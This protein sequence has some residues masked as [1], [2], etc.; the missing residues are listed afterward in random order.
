L[1]SK[2]ADRHLR[3]ARFLYGRRRDALMKALRRV[4][5]DGAKAGTPRG[6]VNVW[7][8]LPP[9]WSSVDLFGYAAREGVLFLPGAAFFPTM[10][11]HNALRLS[12]GTLPEELAPEAMARFGRALRA[13]GAARR[14]GKR[15]AAVDDAAG[16]VAAV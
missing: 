15:L 8:E 2:A 10:P 12:Y 7:V 16:V 9:G 13:Y 6:G 11:A 14:S 1:E 5:P 3:A 4:L